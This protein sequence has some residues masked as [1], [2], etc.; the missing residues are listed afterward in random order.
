[1]TT[2][3]VDG[4]TA[5]IVSDEPGRFSWGATFAGAL[6]A[7]GVTFLLLTLGS[8]IGLSLVTARHA[9]AGGA[10]TFLTM[11]AIYFLAAQAF[12]FAAGGH[13]VGRLIG[14][15][16]ETTQ[17]KD[18]RAGAHG[19]V[20]WALAVVATATIV[21]LSAILAG[22][23]I[24]TG[25]LTA[26][27]GS[28]PANGTRGESSQPATTS[29]WVDKLFRPTTNPQAAALSWRQYAQTDTGTTID[30]PPSNEQPTQPAPADN[31]TGPSDNAP[32]TGSNSRIFMGGGT[33]S[34]APL[35]PVTA[36]PLPTLRPL[37]S[38]KAEAGR[39]LTVGMANGE[40]LS[41][42]DRT[43]LAQ[44]VSLDT[45]M[46]DAA[47]RHRVDDVVQRIHDDEVATAETARKVAAAASLWTA[48]ALLF[49]AVVAVF[50]AVSARWEDDH[51]Q[52]LLPGTRVVETRF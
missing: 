37:G 35:P 16:L 2:T 47:A 12:G 46:S 40:R 5:A 13:V 18:F 24:T 26:A 4:E 17:E 11:G 19:L 30:M 33:P 29:Y 22:S 28:M 43:Q 15:A 14:P 52:G 48:F 25:A 10:T 31:Q 44:L 50:A 38:D 42:E 32:S 9:T 3:I 8:G 39:I 27:L 51:E 34:A 21:A 49:G 36:T 7:M 41:D 20:S 6:V 23:A 1:M 45:G